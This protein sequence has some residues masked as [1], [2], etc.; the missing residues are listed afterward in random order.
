M[1]MCCPWSD[2]NQTNYKFEN[3]D[4]NLRSDSDM[5]GI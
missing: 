4:T 1:L 2:I 5:I 3:K